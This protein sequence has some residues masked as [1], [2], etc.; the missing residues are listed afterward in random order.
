MT[1][2]DAEDEDFILTYP[3]WA[4]ALNPK[5]TGDLKIPYK[6]DSFGHAIAD[7]VKC[8]M[9]FTNEDWARRAV[10]PGVP[11]GSVAGFGMPDTESFAAMLQL[12]QRMGF[13][14]VTFDPNLKK[15]LITTPVKISY[16]LSQI[17]ERDKP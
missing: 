4:I 17:I 7:G 16:I 8:V 11:R 6:V 14:H 9:V 1:E 2:S 5:P 3:L 13:E 10:P 15:K 12:C